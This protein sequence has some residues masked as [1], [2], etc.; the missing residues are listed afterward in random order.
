MLDRLGVVVDDADALLGQEEAMEQDLRDR[1]EDGT[2]VTGALHQITHGGLLFGL[3][4]LLKHLA[5]LER[6]FALP[7]A[8]IVKVG[9]LHDQILGNVILH[10]VCH[11]LWMGGLDVV[12]LGVVVQA[13]GERNLGIGGQREKL[14]QGQLAE[15]TLE[16]LQCRVIRQARACLNHRLV[17]NVLGLAD[18]LQRRGA[19]LFRVGLV[20]ERLLHHLDEGIIP[21]RLATQ[22]TNC[23]RSRNDAK[24]WAGQNLKGLPLRITIPDRSSDVD[25]KLA[26]DDNAWLRMHR[27]EQQ[28]GTQK[29]S[30]GSTLLPR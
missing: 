11:V 25:A 1:R 3:C 22:S 26:S 27:C 19:Q 23:H 4:P 6:I 7:P 21:D 5:H 16:L 30:I 17:I 18:H 20:S 9:T 8:S 28:E 13:F 15:T 29:T 12:H 10:H 14:L 2:D 24:F